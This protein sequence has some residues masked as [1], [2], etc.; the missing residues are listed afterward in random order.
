MRPFAALLL[1]LALALPAQAQESR[2]A[3]DWAGTYVCAQ[4]STGMNLRLR[5][6]GDGRLS[7][8]FHFF[9]LTSN[10]G[11]AEGCYEISATPEGDA[12]TIAA[13]DWLLRPPNYVTVDLDAE[14]DEDGTLFGH[15][16]GPGCTLFAARRVPSRNLPASCGAVVSTR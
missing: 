3:G 11:A 8:V 5:P 4:G 10:P 2:F 7:G 12:A 6:Q 16:I 15:V 14:L 9:P 1:L 13:G